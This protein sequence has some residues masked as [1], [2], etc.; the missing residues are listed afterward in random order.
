MT[1]AVLDGVE[2]VL[3]ASTAH[4]SKELTELRKDRVHVTQAGRAVFCSVGT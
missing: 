1:V 3:R 2:P 4:C